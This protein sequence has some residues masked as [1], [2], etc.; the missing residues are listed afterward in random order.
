MPRS[1]NLSAMRAGQGRVAEHDRQDRVPAGLDREAGLFQGWHAACRA[2]PCSRSRRSLPAA[3]SS[4][5]FS[6]AFEITGG[7]ALEKRYGRERCRRNSTTSAR[8]QVK[9][10]AAPPSALP[11]VLVMMSTR[12]S[13]PS[14]SAEPRPPGPSRPVAWLSST[15]TTAS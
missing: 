15:M 14:C 12:S 13:T 10:P 11:S 9:P 1:S 6:A 4:S 5:A 2:L 7:K 8:P 3:I